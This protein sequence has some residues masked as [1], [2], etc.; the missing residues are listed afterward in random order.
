MLK[1]R[2]M[3]CKTFF[4][5]AC[6]LSHEVTLQESTWCKWR[7]GFFFHSGTCFFDTLF[8]LIITC[9]LKTVS[10]GLVSPLQP[11]YFLLLQTREREGERGK[12]WKTATQVETSR[13]RCLKDLMKN[14]LKDTSAA[15]E[16]CTAF[17]FH[18]RLFA[19]TLCV[20]V[21]NWSDSR[22]PPPPPCFTWSE[23]A[24]HLTRVHTVTRV[25]A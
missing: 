13:T 7:N 4:K 12:N 6:H 8:G 11:A 24:Q 21:L 22:A 18:V 23:H 5:A 14:R 15:T 1:M 25:C 10:A 9:I 17:V 16:E 3:T 2:D 19:D 20:C